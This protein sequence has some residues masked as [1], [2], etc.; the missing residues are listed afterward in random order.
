MPNVLQGCMSRSLTSLFALFLCAPGVIASAATAASGSSPL[1]TVSKAT[2]GMKHMPGLISLDWDAHNGKV[3]FEIPMDGNAARTR[4]PQYI[5]THSTPWSVGTSHLGGY[6]LD[7]GQI[8]EGAIVRFER[9]GPKVLLVEP[10]LDFRSSSSSAAEQAAV[11]ESFPVSV[12]AGFKVAA[13]NA[14][15][16]VLV[17]ATPYFLSDVHHIAEA[18]AQGHQGIYHVDLNRSTILPGETKAFP[19]NSVVEAELTFVEGASELGPT[20]NIV[21]EV[22]PN[23]R[24]VTIRERQMFVRLPPPGYVP[25]RF[26]PNAGYFDFSYRDYDAPLGERMAQQFITRHRLIKKDPHCVTDCQAVTPLHYY[27][28]RGA[29]EPIRQALVEGASWWDQAFQAAGWAPG[30]FKVSVLPKGA[31][32][33]DVRY[34]IIQWVNRFTRGWSYGASVVDPRTGEILKG[35]VTLGGGRGRQDYLIAE[36]LLAPYKNGKPPADEAHDAALQMVLARLRQ[37]AAHETGHTLGLAHNF[38][39]SSYP[40]A[41]EQTVSVMDYPAPHVTVGADGIPDVKHAYPV[42]IGIWDKVAI[43]YGYREFDKDGQRCEDAAALRKILHDAQSRGLIFITDA[44]ARPEGSAHPDAHLWDNGTDA[45]TELDRVLT[46]REA[47]MKRFGVDAIR[48]GTP[49]ARLEDLLVPLYLFHRYQTVAAAKEI[50]GLD[51]RYNVRGDGQM[52]PKMVAPAEQEH[53]LKSVLK[54]LSPAMLTLPEPLLKVLPPRP[55]GLH[56][57]MEDFP[58]R[59]GVTFDPLGA[60]E[61]AADLT[62]ALLFNPE[63]DNRLVQYHAEDAAEPSLQSVIEATLDSTAIPAGTTGLEVEVKHAVDHQIVEALLRL[64]ANPGDSAETAAIARYE[65]TKLEKQLTSQPGSDVE[66]QALDAMEA[67]EIHAFFENPAKYVPAPVV[68]APPGMPIGD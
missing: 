59:T 11:K 22:T 58:S 31:D 26:S 65:L 9:T 61:S 42:G 6:G 21:S 49:L 54:T 56:R 20:G 23:P 7:R 43:D 2:A 57:T 64:A 45:A 62:L 13:E 12:L 63:R 35:N 19:D 16:T 51:Y 25:R 38:A 28:D 47:A 10:N 66:D 39:A 4:S 41:P 60:A 68:Q 44:D 32:P 52:L 55:P 46:V 1:P 37:L 29:P 53:A 36:A 5:Y 27:V 40:H 24:A 18:L 14:D 8:S 3:Y 33:M 30:T 15:G 34:N 17:D 50:G 67:E 48:E